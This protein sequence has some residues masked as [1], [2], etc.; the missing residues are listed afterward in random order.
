MISNK[1][2]LCATASIAPNEI[3]LVIDSAAAGGI[4]TH[5]KELI[6]GLHRHHRPARVIILQRYQHQPL[7]DILADLMMPYSFLADLSPAATILQRLCNAV[8]RYQPTLL[9]AHGYKASLLT[10]LVKLVTDIAQI[11]TYHA[12][13]TPKGRVRLYDWLDRYSSFLSD[14]CLCVSPAIARKIPSPTCLINNFIT[15]PP[16]ALPS[17]CSSE[18]SSKIHIAFV[19]RL[20]AEK[21]PERFVRL[22]GAFPELTFDLYGDGPMLQALSDLAPQNLVFHGYVQDMQPIWPKITLLMIPS[23]FEGLPMVS[24]EAMGRGIPVIATRVGAMPTLITHGQNGWIADTPEALTTY[25][26]HWLSL[27]EH[28]KAHIGQCARHT[29]RHAYSDHAVIPKILAHYQHV[30]SG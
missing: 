6:R 10:R 8:K 29:I 5:V 14:R 2:D 17:E 24:L 4:E 15:C 18:Q 27:S 12:G 23:R 1:P 3:W 16:P 22:A 25:L 11:S 13:E 7:P 9:H 28:Q 20:S 21:A 26:K 19:G 30:V